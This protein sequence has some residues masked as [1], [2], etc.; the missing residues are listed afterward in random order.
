MIFNLNQEECCYILGFFWADAYFGKG[1]RK[2][3]YEFS[4]EIK[5]DDFLN[6]WDYLQ[7]IGFSKY[8]TRKRKNS[9]NPQSRVRLYRQESL[10]F[11]EKYKFHLKNDGCPLY[12]DIAD[13]MKPFFIKGFLDGDGSISLDKNNGF[14]VG[15]NG[16]KNQSWDFLEDFCNKRNIKFSI[17][18]KD[19][20]SKHE[21]HKKEIHG[22]SVLEPTNRENRLKLCKALDLNIGLSRKINVYK[23]YKESQDCIKMQKNL[24]KKE[25]SD[26]KL[27]TVSNGIKRNFYNK[28]I[29]YSILRKPGI[30]KYIG[31]FNSYEEA[32]K[33]QENFPPECA[34]PIKL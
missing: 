7:N 14:R 23:K 17:Y 24:I 3:T 28:F 13:D 10:T 29:T 4:F 31:T 21:T 9:K 6:V 25:K 19:R 12:F 26:Y 1:N 34:T 8:K 27:K 2:N 15:F 16:S 33:A 11:F 5:T 22:Y 20:I 32:V 30:L 18:R